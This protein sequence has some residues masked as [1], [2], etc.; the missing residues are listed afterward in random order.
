M[1][2]YKQWAFLWTGSYTEPG[3]YRYIYPLSIGLPSSPGVITNPA[4][5]IWTDTDNG[6]IPVPG[7]SLGDNQYILLSQ[8]YMRWML[9]FGFPG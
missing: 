1:L 3:T 8:S 6:G 2:S 4:W 9:A 7:I 5:V